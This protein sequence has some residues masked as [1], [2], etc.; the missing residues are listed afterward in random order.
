[1]T[2][3]RIDPSE[4]L[5]RELGERPTDPTKRWT[6]DQAVAGIE[7][8]RQQHGVRDKDAALGAPDGD[9][10]AKL[11]HKQATKAL[12]RAQRQLGLEREQARV[13]E[14]T[15]GLEIEL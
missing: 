12:K 6:W 4:Y 7:A 15:R 14:Q 11:E 5:T 10:P 9:S 2:A 13:R 3:V 1:M 8:Y